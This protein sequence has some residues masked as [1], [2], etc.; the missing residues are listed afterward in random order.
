MFMKMTQYYM[1]KLY[2]Y[3]RMTMVL[4][5]IIEYIESTQSRIVIVIYIN[6][7]M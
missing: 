2:G 6:T 5:L 4:C 1:T 7:K 3:D